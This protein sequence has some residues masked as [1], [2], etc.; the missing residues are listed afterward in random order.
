VAQLGQPGSRHEPHVPRPKDDK[1]H[2][3]AQPL[4]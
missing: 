2:G 1:L 3:R 4:A